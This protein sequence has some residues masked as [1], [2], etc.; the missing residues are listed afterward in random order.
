MKTLDNN[1]QVQQP[2]IWVI[3]LETNRRFHRFEIPQSIVTR[4]NGLASI[5]VDVDRSN[6]DDAYAYIP[7]LANYYL[8]VY[9]LKQNRIWQFHH[10]SFS[11]DPNNSDFD[12]G[13]VQFQWNDGIFSITLGPRQPNGY[14]IAN[15]HAM[16]SL[17]SYAVST[18]ILQNQTAS[19]RSYH[20]ND[21]MVSF[22]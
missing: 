22:F 1:I 14:R 8:G 20:E 9:S 12:V 4:G 18:R 21:F 5:T 6:C 16:A 10:N 11:F 19:M 2:S 17:N 13:G 15:F 3:D 7:D